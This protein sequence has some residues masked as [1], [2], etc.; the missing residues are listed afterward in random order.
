MKKRLVFAFFALAAACASVADDGAGQRDLQKLLDEAAQAGEKE[1]KLKGTYYV[2]KPVL[3]TSAHS[4]MKIDG[5]ETAKISGAKR[6]VN[7]RQQGDLWVG[8]VET[9]RLENLFVNGVRA[10]PAESEFRYVHSK[11]KVTKN[12]KGEPIDP[13]K[14]GFVARAED[15]KELLSMTPEQLKNAEID[16]YIVWYNMHVKVLG[17][18]KNKNG[19]VNVFTTN[20]SGFRLYQWERFPRF[21]IRNVPAFLDAAGEFAFDAATKTFAYKPRPGQL[22]QAAEVLYP[23]VS[24]VLEVKGGENSYATD[25]KFE[26]VTFQHGGHFPGDGWSQAPQAQATVGGFVSVSYAKNFEMKNCVIE[27]CNTYGLSLGACV[28]GA[29]IEENVIFDT[30]SGGIR[31]GETNPAK[32]FTFGNEISDNIIYSYGRYNKAGVGIAIFKSG[33]NLVEHNTIF[34]GYYSGMSIGWTWGFSPTNTQNNRI[35]NNRIFKIGHGVLDDMGGIYTLGDATGSVIKGNEISGVRRHRYGGWGIYNDEGSHGFYIADNYVHDT[36][37]DGYFQHYGTNNL[38]KNNIFENA[39][40][41]QVGLGRKNYNDSFFFTRNIVIYSSPAGLFRSNDVISRQTASFDNNIYWNKNGDVSFSGLTLQQWQE[42]GQDK[43]SF[44]VDPAWNGSAF[45][46]D[47]YKKIGFRPFS[48]KDAGV[49]G[50]MKKVLDAILAKHVFPEVVRCDP[51]P[52]WGMDFEEDFSNCELSKTPPNIGAFTDKKDRDIVVLQENGKRFLRMIDGKNKEDY[53]PFI[54]LSATIKSKTAKMKFQMRVSNDCNF[55]VEFR[56]DAY[57]GGLPSISV[58]DG[59]LVTPDGPV[60][61]PVGKWLSVEF[62]VELAKDLNRTVRCTVK[63]GARLIKSY[64][65]RYTA[66]AL[67]GATVVVISSAGEKGTFDLADI[68]ILNTKD[69]K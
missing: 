16:L 48:T 3:L 10:I 53:M 35:L 33:N 69:K 49:R 59:K 41:T 62:D 45:G 32:D 1:V 6:A 2:E 55:T 8:Q 65:T 7:L 50:D 54:N 36:H 19:T 22:F 57:V 58:R 39:E 18:S 38:I 64:Q 52:P 12:H 42:K 51:E 63:E 23:V 40:V 5:D 13:E 68:K 61:L 47:N 46:N 9:D 24:Q 43:G 44:V 56:K 14:G 27:H 60:A 20:P 66:E 34:D 30:G 4:G 15:V 67:G 25:I 17:L 37:E 29:K 31:L 28:E 26:G 21:K 11:L